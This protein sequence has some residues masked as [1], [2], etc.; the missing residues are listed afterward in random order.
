MQTDSSENS[1]MIWFW[2]GSVLSSLLFLLLVKSIW[3]DSTPFDTFQFFKENNVFAGIKASWPIFLWGAGITTLIAFST[4][5][6]K[7]LNHEAEKILV[8]GLATSVVAG[9]FEELAF[10]WT[11]FLSSIIAAKFGNYL[12][13]GWLGFGLGEQL[14]MNFFGPIVNFFTLGK[15]KWLIYDMGWAVGAAALAANAKFRSGHAY[16]G[17]FGL[18]NSWIIGF[19]LFWI[20]FTYGLWAAIIVHFLYDL[21][22][23]IIR[24]TDA[25]IERHFGWGHPE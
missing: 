3:P 2:I 19:F 22:I 15:M 1:G 10:R 8:D 20:M 5:N 25:A 9:I 16:L 14:H 23:Y 4:L 18:I 17:G 7:T 13:F 6:K 24:Y 12:F 21:F 11:I